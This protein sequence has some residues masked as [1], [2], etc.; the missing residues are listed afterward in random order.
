MHK[1]LVFSPYEIAEPAASEH[2]VNLVKGDNDTTTVAKDVSLQ[3]LY[4]N[5]VKPGYMLYL[6][7]PLKKA[8][9]ENLKKLMSENIPGEVR[10]YAM[11]KAHTHF[12]KVEA[13][14]K[15]HQL[16]ALK[17]II[18]RLSSPVE[19]FKLSLDRAYQ[20]IANGSPVEIR[21]RIKGA[22]VGK[23]ERLK[24]GDA[25]AW[26][27]MHDHFPHLR[28]DF[29]LKAMPEGS[30]YLIKPVSDGRTVQFVI[31]KPAKKMPRVDL[32][33]RLLS[34][35]KSVEQSVVSGRQGQLPRALRAQVQAAGHKEYA[36]RTGMPRPQATQRGEG[37]D[38]A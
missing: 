15:G 27:W 1:V 29:I 6:T 23:E 37:E 25:N 12:V 19:Y 11:A 31:S 13:A 38:A 10:N 24:P 8:T 7:Q 18:V 32:N 22:H 9:A 35:Q 17:V 4:D 34:V 28:P 14:Q 30:M 20:F 26:P 36:V 16:G 2:K 5:H 3:E 33:K 21:I